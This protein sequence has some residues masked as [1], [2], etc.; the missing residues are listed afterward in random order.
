M[1]TDRL[2]DL[3]LTRLHD[4]RWH[5]VNTPQGPVAVRPDGYLARVDPWID[6]DRSSVETGQTPER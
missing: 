4:G 3:D 2:P 6:R 5:V 1:T